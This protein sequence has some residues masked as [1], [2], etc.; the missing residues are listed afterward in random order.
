ME[1]KHAYNIPCQRL[2]DKMDVNREVVGGTWLTLL[3][4]RL[5]SKPGHK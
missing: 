2:D 3:L 4:L 1:R 5:T